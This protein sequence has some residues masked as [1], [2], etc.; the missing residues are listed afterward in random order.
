[1]AGIQVN[2]TVSGLVLPTEVSADIWQSAIEQSAVLSLAQRT[3]LPGTGKSIQTITGDPVADWVDETDEKP[4]SRPSLGSK[5]MTPYK[6]AVIVPFSNEFRRDFAR[7]YGELVKRLP[8]ALGAKLDATVFHGTAPGSNF[9]VLTNA[10]KIAVGGDDPYAGFVE[11]D[12]EVA[13]NG[14]LIDGYAMAP[15]ARPLLLGARDGFNRPL[16]TPGV[17][18]RDIVGPLG[19]PIRFHKA[20]YKAGTG[21]AANVIGFAGDW[22]SALVGIVQDVTVDIS[23]QATLTEYVDDG[24]GGTEAQH[25]NLWQRNMFAVRAEMEVGFIVKDVDHFVALTD[26]DRDEGAGS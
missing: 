16:F 13:L 5:S 24:N 7:L 18:S 12:A 4:V 2:R 1:M 21:G 11:A 8:A 23:D 10:T 22:S 26:E 14:A 20:V 25:I 6:L 9:D 15:Q 17:G 3:D 19:A